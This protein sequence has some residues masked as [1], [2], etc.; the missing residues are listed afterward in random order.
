MELVALV[1][2]AGLG[3]ALLYM[4]RQPSPAARLRAA[5]RVLGLELEDGVDGGPQLVSQEE[6]L[7]LTFT[8]DDGTEQPHL[9]GALYGDVGVPTMVCDVEGE[10]PSGGHWLGD[11]DLS[12][13][14]AMGVVYAPEEDELGFDGRFASEMAA[15]LD[16][17]ARETLTGL[18]GLARYH[19]RAGAV[20]GTVPMRS[21][22]VSP[23][24]LMQLTLAVARLLSLRGHSV[25]GLLLR[26]AERDVPAIR[27][28]CLKHLIARYPDSDEGRRAF[29]LAEAEHDSELRLL[30]ALRRREGRDEALEAV[31]RSDQSHPSVRARAIHLLD[32]H[33]TPER[34]SRM[35]AHLVG[36]RARLVQ[37]AAVRA[38]REGRDAA[39]TPALIAQCETATRELTVALAEAFEALADPAAEPAVLGFLA[40]DDEE[41]LIPSLAALGV[42]GTAASVPRLTEL[43]SDVFLSRPL[44]D[45]VRRTLALV[46]SRLIDA[47]AGALSLADE[48]P[49]RGALSIAREHGGLSLADDEED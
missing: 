13:H 20:R 31:A 38:V 5:A 6:G 14:L 39:L 36:D 4:G 2:F 3:A 9:G 35:L 15:V 30:V 34:V 37:L 29:V 32:R 19:V 41:V 40:T 26:N 48:D 1:L 25:R 21:G 11:Q 22:T 42:I 7:R 49:A 33:G 17:E 43:E 28:H 12:W 10:F 27:R 24:E 47:E 44:R 16:T 46:R 8:I 18:L 23:L 45:A